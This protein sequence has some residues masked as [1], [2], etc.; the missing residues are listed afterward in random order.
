MTNAE[1]LRRVNDAG[2]VVVRHGRL[3]LSASIVAACAGAIASLLI[4]RSELNNLEKRT[5]KI[6][7]KHETVATKEDLKS[8]S[9]RLDNIYNL[10]I[11]RQES[12]P[13]F[14]KRP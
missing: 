1:A 3:Y 13:P 12:R 4:A 7:L 9:D 6:E 14:P 11:G 5:E 8:V 2:E 10:L